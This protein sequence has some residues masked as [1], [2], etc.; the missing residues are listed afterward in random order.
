MNSYEAMFIVNPNLN[1]EQKKDA[2]NQLNDVIIKNQGE[3]VNSAVWSEKRK[4]CYAIKKFQEG[5]YFLVNFKVSPSAITK[6]KQV[7]KL[8]E[9]IIRMLLL[10]IE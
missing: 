4:L 9:N 8:N 10:K 5:I 6:I 3:V 1:E 2:L 7:Y